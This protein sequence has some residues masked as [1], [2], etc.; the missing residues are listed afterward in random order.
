METAEH[1]KHLAREGQL[2][3]DAAE[4]AGSDAEVRSCPGWTVR[5]LLRHTGMVHR[6]ATAFVADGHTSY[7]PGGGEPDLDG[8]ALLDWY[9]EGHDLL[10]AALSGA[11]DSLECWTFLPAPSPPAFWARRQAHETT[12]HR[13]DAESALGLVAGRSPVAPELA[14]D[15]IDELLCGFH[16]RDKSRV[17]TDP[18]G[19]LRVRTTDTD[20]V[21]TV[22]LSADAPRTTRTADGPAECELTGPAEALY[23]SLWNRLPAGTPAVTVTGDDRLARLW[24]ETSAV[25]W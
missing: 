24:R 22:T 18:P 13:V 2:L 8:A 16:G 14:A 11:P 4:Q 7:R 1:I 15:G 25:T 17:R 6:W 9:R 5:D 23:L 21:W 12:V 19:A 3:A 10:V 20:D